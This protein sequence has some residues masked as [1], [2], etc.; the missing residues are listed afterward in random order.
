MRR[1]AI[2][3]LPLVA[4][5]GGCAASHPVDF[6]RLR[7]IAPGI[8]QDMRYAGPHNFVGRRVDG[9]EQGECWL[10]TPTAQALKAVQ[11]DLRQRGDGLEL[12]VFDCYRPQRAVAH[13][14]RWAADIDDTLTRAEFYP[15]IDKR[16]LFRLGYIAERS[17]HSRGS[18]VDVTLT[19][20]TARPAQNYQAGQPLVAC[21][22]AYTARFAD[23]GVDMGTGYDCFDDASAPDSQAVNATA[24]A[25]RRILTQAMAARGF[26]ALSTEY[27]HFTLNA[28]PYPDSYFDFVVR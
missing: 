1:L 22:A 10:T 2:V 14:A 9:Y 26:R 20:P 28:E 6:V 5:L 15:T 3:V 11:D 13:F 4:L 25:N 8:R 23:G 24:Q 19:G 27:W 17:G 12:Q 7:D 18:T 16:D 21:T